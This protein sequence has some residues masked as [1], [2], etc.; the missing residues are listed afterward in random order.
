MQNN[1]TD[2]HNHVEN[3]LVG[4]ILVV[5]RT[6]N[7]QFCCVLVP[8]SLRSILKLWQ[9]KSW[10]QSGHHVVNFSTWCFGIYKTVHRIWLRILSIAFEK[11]L[12]TLSY[13]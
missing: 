10:V 2:S 7:L 9:L 1:T 13:A 6:V 5:L 11:K 8:I 4:V 12:K 3:R